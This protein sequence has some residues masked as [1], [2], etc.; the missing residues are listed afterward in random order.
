MRVLRRPKD[1]DAV[2]RTHAQ[3][4]QHD[5]VGA[6]RAALAALLPVYCFVDFVAGPSQHHRKRCAHVALVVDDENLRHPSVSSLKP[7]PVI[8]YRGW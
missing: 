2:L 8:E 5:I 6:G 7:G 1:V 4:R 3:V